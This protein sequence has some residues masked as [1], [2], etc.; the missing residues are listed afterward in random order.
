MKKTVSA[1]D[2]PAALGPY[3]HA[4]WAGDFLYCSGQL[5]LDPA[6]GAMAGSGVSS[7]TER[8]IENIAALLASQGLALT[9]VVKSMVFL[10]DMGDF[11]AFNEAYGKYFP[12]E[13]PARSCV[14][15]AA[16]PAGAL[17]EIEVVAHK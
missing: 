10:A 13:P 4:V 6:T 3:S 9:D 5:G 14:G 15:V 1:K 12:S 8:A 2:L 7:Q 11:K 16:L 17:V